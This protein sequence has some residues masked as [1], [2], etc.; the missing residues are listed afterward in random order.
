MRLRKVLR[1]LG[2]PKL[3]WDWMATRCAS[4]EHRRRFLESWHSYGGSDVW[5]DPCMSSQHWRA[6]AEERLAVH[7]IADVWEINAETVRELASLRGLNDLESSQAWNLAW[8]VFYALENDRK[9]RQ[10]AER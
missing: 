10:V 8:R 2:R 6:A 1:R 9:R 4:C 7:L 3:V 5:H